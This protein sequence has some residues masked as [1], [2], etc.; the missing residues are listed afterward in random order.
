[1]ALM[2]VAYRLAGWG[3][4]VLMVDMDLEAP[5]L[6]RT[7]EFSACPPGDVIDLLSDAI[8]ALDGRPASREFAERLPPLSNYVRSVVDDKLAPLTPKFGQLGRLDLIG[9]D[10][11]RD[12]LERHAHLGLKGLDRSHVAEVSKLLHYYIKAQR[13]AHRPF[14]F[15]DFELPQETPYDY[16]LVDSRTGITEIG[17]LCVGPLSDRL[18]V[19]TGLNKQSIA[20]TLEV[21]QEV[22]ILAK[23]RSKSAERWDDADI[24]SDQ[25]PDL[26][27]KPTIVVASPLP[28]QEITL[29]EER[30]LKVQAA[31]GVNP[32]RL[33]YHPLLALVETVFV[34]D[35]PDQY[36]ASDYSTLSSAIMGQIGDDRAMLM[37]TVA[38]RI[39]SKQNLDSLSQMVLRL[40][41]LE[42]DTNWIR[43]ASTAM[44]SHFDAGSLEVPRWRAIHA[45]LS[46]S[47]STAPYAL[48]NWGTE[49]QDLAQKTSGQEAENFLEAAIRK[50]CRALETKPDHTDALI[51][52]G[53]A[54][55][56]QAERARPPESDSLHASAMEKFNE[57]LKL[58]PR[59]VEA[60]CCRGLALFSHDKSLLHDAKQDLLKVEELSPGFAAFGLARMAAFERDATNAIAWL[61][62]GPTVTKA[63]LANEGEFDALTNDPGYQSFLAT[64]PEN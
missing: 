28:L 20:G 7:D 9:V 37:S 36:L 15:E 51:G 5:G 13:F 63:L 44:K 62:K 31:L 33:H 3:R 55:V 38:A 54:L 4:H 50:Y 42:S 61:R 52:W 46:E 64:L 24:V 35:Y 25:T 45:L 27:P 26:G 49:L 30:L 58:D 43:L 40:V 29:Q 14:W 41:P 60:L 48:A 2:N 32:I 57:A 34:R 39:E 23:S 59:S 10:L 22:G 16:V 47:A 1:M 56:R 21:L 17:G 11:N 8:S 19:L 53:A 12:H 6:S 18:V